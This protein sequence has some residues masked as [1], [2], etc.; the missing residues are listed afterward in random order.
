MN[1]NLIEKAKAQIGK[2][3][4][5]EVKE[6][7]EGF[8]NVVFHN[9]KLIF[10]AW[11]QNFK[12]EREYLATKELWLNTLIDEKVTTPEQIDRAIKGAKLADSAFFPSIGQFIKWSQKEAPRVNEDAYK[13][14]AA[15]LRPHTVDEYA[16]IANRKAKEIKQ[17]DYSHLSV[18]EQLAML[19]GGK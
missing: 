5:V 17:A 7:S 10:P 15:K 2:A 3:S 9:L 6:Q 14:H 18:D 13:V 4:D 1:N 12:T 16:E 19:K 11:R 8:I